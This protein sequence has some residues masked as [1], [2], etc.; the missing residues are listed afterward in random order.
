MDKCMICNHPQREAIEAGLFRMHPENSTAVLLSLAEAFD[1]PVEELQ[2]HAL[3][4]TSFDCSPTGDSIVR[5]IK[6]KEADMLASVALDQLETIKSV[7]KRMRG[8]IKNSNEDDL[9]FENVLT[10]PVVDLYVGASDSLRKNIQTI[11]DINNLLNGPKDNGLAGLN[12][13]AQAL[14][15]SRSD[16]E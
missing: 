8:H 7:G 6:M 3:F 1:V 5:Q 2:K 11:A 12:A 16:P 10:K 14:H 13:L 4:H 9:K 15:G